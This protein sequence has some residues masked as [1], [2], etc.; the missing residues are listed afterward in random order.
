MLSFLCVLICWTTFW[1]FNHFVNKHET[2][3]DSTINGIYIVPWNKKFS[4]MNYI[5]PLIYKIRIWKWKIVL[6]LELEHYQVMWFRNT[7]CPY[8]L[9]S[10]RVRDMPSGYLNF[11]LSI[12]NFTLFM[13]YFA[14]MLSWTYS[15]FYRFSLF[16][17]K[18]H[19]SNTSLPYSN[20]IFEWNSCVTY[21]QWSGFFPGSEY[22]N[23]FPYTTSSCPFGGQEEGKEE[24]KW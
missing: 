13:P 9:S 23:M 20:N 5:I 19:F 18:I 17:L 8:L 4:K 1:P 24:G 6:R 14:Y 11:T 3:F 15:I 2:C 7:W 10:S 22:F 12:L 21:Y 16:P